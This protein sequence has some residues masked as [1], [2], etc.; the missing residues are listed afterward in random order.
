MLTTVDEHRRK[1]AIFWFAIPPPVVAR[2]L[3]K[4]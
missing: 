1:V 4:R 3:S 2:L